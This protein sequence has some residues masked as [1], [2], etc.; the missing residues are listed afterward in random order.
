MSERNFARVFRSEAGVTPAEFVECARIDA[1][2]RRV[3]E[4]EVPLKRLAEDVGYANADGLR[5]AFVR[6]LGVG[7]NDY[8]K[9]FATEG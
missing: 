3:E 7:P 1:A 5:R 2:R 4:S 9:R 6:R 8:R